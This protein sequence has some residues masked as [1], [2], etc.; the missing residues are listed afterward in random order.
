[1]SL[2]INSTLIK[3]VMPSFASYIA[4]CFLLCIAT[5]IHKC[6]K[7]WSYMKECSHIILAF[8]KVLSVD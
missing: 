6:W 2:K 8:A 7:R 1:M 5:Y 3:H 4:M